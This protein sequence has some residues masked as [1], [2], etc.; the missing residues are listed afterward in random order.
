MSLDEEALQTA[1]NGGQMDLERW[2]GMAGPLIERLEYIVYNVFPMPQA[3][4]DPIGQPLFPNHS[5]QANSIPPESSN[6]ENTSP[7]DIQTLPQAARTGSPPSSERVPESQPQPSGA[8]TD[9]QLPPPLAFLLSAIR[10]SI[11]SFFE[12]KPPHTIQRLAE[13]VLYPTKHY[14]TLPAYLRAVDRVVSVTSSADV[15]PFQT[16]AVTNAPTNGL[17]LPGNS[18]GVYT[19]PDFA[20]GLGS[21]ES[22]GGALLTP[23]PWLTNAS[24]E[25]EDTNGDAGI[26]V[27]GTE[28][29]PTQPQE[30][31]STTTL[32][33]TEAEE[34]ATTA[35]PE[36]SDEVPHARGPILLGVED[37][38]LQDGK[39]VEMR[40]SGD[41]AADVPA[42]AAAT[43]TQAMEEQEKAGST[44][45][46]DGDIVLAD[47]KPNEEEEAKNEG[48]ST[49][50][51]TGNAES[52]PTG[53]SSQAPDAEKKA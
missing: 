40:L 43:A 48:L 2:N 33:T 42:A 24:F 26:L 41:G 39:G 49:E 36:P 5:S 44:G 17:V 10:S 18:S 38:G 13:L 46:K 11:K 7:A 29:L 32:V 16:P 51:Q 47:T 15:F 27:K 34:S 9:G 3:R 28:A 53:D 6:K 12:D 22:L 50:P 1:A 30:E 52:E 25:G 23:I 37:M 8:S 35:S 31:P 14:R 20:H 21:D 45:D 19:A 4:P